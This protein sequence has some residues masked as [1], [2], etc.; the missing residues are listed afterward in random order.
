MRDFAQSLKSNE[1]QQELSSASTEQALFVVFKDAIWRH[2]IASAWFTFRSDA[3]KQIAIKW[4]DHPT[5]SR[6]ACRRSGDCGSAV[7]WQRR[8]RGPE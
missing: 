2:D 1:I 5:C 7:G 3:L 4:C 8:A 6:E